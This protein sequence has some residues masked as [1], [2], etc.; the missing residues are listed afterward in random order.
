MLSLQTSRPRLST[1]FRPFLELL[2]L[3]SLLNC[4][5]VAWAQNPSANLDPATINRIKEEELKHSQLREAVSYLSDVAGPRLTGSPNLKAAQEW[6]RNK[7]TEWGLHD[8]HL[9]PWGPFGRGWTLEGF[10]ANMTAPAF[11]PL[12]AYPKAWSPSTPGTVRGNVVYLDVRTAADLEKY[13]GKLKGAIVLFLPAR[14]LQTHFESQ[15]HRATDEELSKL[16]Q[17][18][19]P[20]AGRRFELTPEQRAQ[21]DLSFKKWQLVYDE[22]AAV[23]LSPAPRGDFGTIYVTSATMPI[24]FDM[25]SEQR[26]QPWAPGAVVIPQAVV[27]LEHY[28]RIIRLLERG[29]PVQLEVNIQSRFYDQ[30]LMSYNVIAEIP[31][32]D[33]KDEIV[34]IGGCLDSWHAGTGATDNAAGAATVLEVAR[35]IQTLGLKPRRTIRIALWSAEEQGTLGSRAYVAAHLGK[36]GASQFLPEYEKFAGY[37]NLDGGTGKIR[38]VFLQGNEAVRP[39][40]RAWLAPFADLGASTLSILN[41]VDTDHVAFDDIGLPGFMFIRD[42]IEYDT[43]TAHTNMDFYDHIQEDDLKQAAIIAASFVYQAAMRDVKLPRKKKQSEV[44]K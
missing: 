18:V 17:A 1:R 3:T 12:I 33:L 16:A 11:A 44:G 7:L 9:E 2:L 25:P 26:P 38:G 42:E 43:R 37:F 21:Q 34:M 29:L 22:H 19:P 32:S 27:A 23:V 5:V 39:I 30:D 40:F 41:S 31:G 8:A 28:N 24:P 36:R 10:T 14:P 6:S 15:A 4:G 35:L 13:R 20:P